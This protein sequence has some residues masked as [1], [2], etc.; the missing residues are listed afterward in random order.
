M[1]QTYPNSTA[2][3]GSVV[4]VVW[5]ISVKIKIS[6]LEDGARTHQDM[7]CEIKYNGNPGLVINS[8][9]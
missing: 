3:G 8:N 4:I 1:S 9:Y 5:K 2:T 7:D 6:C